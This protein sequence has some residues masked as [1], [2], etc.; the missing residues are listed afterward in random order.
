MLLLI[1]YK[2]DGWTLVPSC[3]MDHVSSG[4]QNRKTIIILLDKEDGMSV[5]EKNDCSR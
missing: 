3:M 5:E 2:F 1:P 4:H